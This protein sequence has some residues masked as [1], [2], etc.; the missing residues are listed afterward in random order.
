MKRII[1]NESEKK[2]ILLKHNLLFEGTAE[3]QQ[4]MMKFKNDFMSK[5]DAYIADGLEKMKSAPGLTEDE[6]GELQQAINALRKGGMMAGAAKSLVDSKFNEYI[7]KSPDK[8]KGML[9][10]LINQH[11]EYSNPE[12]KSFCTGNPKP[13]ENKKVEEP[14]KTEVNKTTNPYAPG[15]I[16]NPYG[17]D[18][19]VYAPGSIANPYGT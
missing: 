2:Q 6:K 4:V 14:S 13:E 16:A 10:Y 15:S 18:T 7:Q 19:N 1:I 9:C 12:I 8:A 11:T 3:D 5:Q 17:T